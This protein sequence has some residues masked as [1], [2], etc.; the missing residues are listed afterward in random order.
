MH[1][2]QTSPPRK[3]RDAPQPTDIADRMIAIQRKIASL[4]RPRDRL[5][6]TS[7]AVVA[8]SAARRS[9]PSPRRPPHPPSPKVLEPS[10]DAFNRP[11]ISSSHRRAVLFNWET[12][13]V[14]VRRTTEPEAVS[15]A[16]SHASKS[17]PE[18]TQRLQRQ[19][20]D[21][22]CE[23]PVRFTVQK[24]PT[25]DYNSVSS[26]S[27]Y[28]ASFT[29]SNFI[30]PLNS[31]TEDSSARTPL[32]KHK[33]RDDSKIN[34]FSAQ[35]KK[36]YRDIS[37]LEAK[38]VQEPGETSAD[39]SLL[40]SKG[41]T[42]S[43]ESENGRWKKTMA[44]HKLLAEMMHDLLQI[45][46]AHN[47]PASLRNI[48]EK[49]NII[50]RLWTHAFHRLL[51]HLRRASLNSRIAMEHLQD[52]IYYAYTFYT[53]LV[54]EENLSSFKWEWLEA[55]GDLARYRMAIASMVPVLTLQPSSLTAAAI[56][57]NASL[58]TPTSTTANASGAEASTHSSEKPAAAARIDDATSPSVGIAA[59]R[60]M[61]LE[62]EKERWRSI[63]RDW[64]A[65]GVA[66]TPG[67]GK[68]HH[69]LGLLSREAEGEELRGV[70][71]FVKSM[72]VTRPFDTSRQSILSIW[73]QAAQARRAA[74]DA[75][76]SELFIL[77]HG[78]L[79]TLVQLDDFSPT[80]A[81]LLERLAI[82]APE[83]PEWTMMA[84]VNI[85]ALLEY[86]K[87]PAKKLA[88]KAAAPEE[89]DRRTDEVQ[90]STAASEESVGS[91]PPPAFLMA[92]QL[93]FS[94]LVYA[95]DRSAGAVP[96]TYITV[97]LSF[98]PIFFKNAQAL[99]LLERSV[100]W[101]KIANFLVGALSH[102]LKLGNTGESIPKRCLLDEDWLIRGMAWPSCK[103]FEHG[104]W[105][106]SEGQRMEMK[107]PKEQVVEEDEDEA[108]HKHKTDS[109]EA[110]RWQRA[111]WAGA[112]LTVL[113]DGFVWDKASSRAEPNWRM[114]DPLQQRVR[115]WEEEA[116]A[117]QEEEERRKHGTQWTDSEDKMGV[118]E[119][120]LE[121]AEDSSGPSDDEDDSYEVRAFK[122]PPLSWITDLTHVPQ[123]R[124]RYLQNLCSSPSPAL[125]PRPRTSHRAAPPSRPTRQ[126]RPGYTMV[127]IDTN[128]LLSSLSM[129][130]SLVESGQW[131]IVIPL[132]VIKELDRLRTNTNDMPL[133][134][135]MKVEVL[136]L[137]S[138][139][140]QY[141]RLRGN[142]LSLLSLRS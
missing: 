39:N 113:V 123:A 62:P 90:S 108:K 73:S 134:E 112:R 118:K 91:E 94:M 88:K 135:A 110:L 104:F 92:Q 74:P 66:T 29:S 127:V 24:R 87:P 47:V 52:F 36:L 139:V 45:S 13:A 50:I 126:L 43:E 111:V 21:Y 95:L 64:Y 79:F 120:E 49:Y 84:I 93:T 141:A 31:T 28:A 97:I 57:S 136:Y 83:T 41:W 69:H 117:E 138:H 140:R 16:S 3:Q 10:T 71:H 9:R 7:S 19:L 38:I 67:N 22:R 77:L 20:F 27:S 59:A 107:V 103:M 55:L 80:L 1:L 99:A 102:A 130:S 133:G 109:A 124:Q 6:R 131:T 100:P 53:G 14:L 106:S 54:E 48:P 25:H 32:L 89:D 34:S 142:H 12:D 137:T 58:S 128:V 105:D 132:Q 76:A 85:G 40:L 23:D 96:N 101:E 115:A 65:S 4:T 70:Y 15:D 46:L 61:E 8:V 17:K 68:L 119:D 114:E 86:G 42:G 72:I 56:R 98:L 75:H 125:L 121:L 44:D 18:P 116:R 78:I 26:V 82:D 33:S 11:K 51:E 129:V 2:E 63:A 81:R 60:M 35:L 30:L 5:E 37:T 122:V